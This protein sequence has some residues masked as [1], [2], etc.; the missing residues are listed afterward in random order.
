MNFKNFVLSL[1]LFSLILFFN[2]GCMSKDNSKGNIETPCNLR[3]SRVK[4]FIEDQQLCITGE[5]INFS[6]ENRVIEIK[7]IQSLSGGQGYYFNNT[8]SENMRGSLTIILRESDFY[9]IYI[10]GMYY[11]LTPNKS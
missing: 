10:N 6:F 8:V 4:S 11:Y 1:F 7:K 5:D 2:A 9:H 3:V